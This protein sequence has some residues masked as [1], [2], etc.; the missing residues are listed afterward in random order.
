MGEQARR[1]DSSS[2]ANLNSAADMI[3]SSLASSIDNHAGRHTCSPRDGCS[4]E[5]KHH[6]TKARLRAVRSR[7]NLSTEGA[8]QRCRADPIW[9]HHVTNHK[10][11][12]SITGCVEATR[13]CAIQWD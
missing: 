4:L 13:K 3:A 2:R 11:Q 6:F 1:Q 10:L 12:C 8:A 5:F 7:A 9:L